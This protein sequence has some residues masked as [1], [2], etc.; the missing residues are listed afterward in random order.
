MNA[1]LIFLMNANLCEGTGININ[2]CNGGETSV[3]PRVWAG[4]SLFER[5]WA[6]T[7]KKY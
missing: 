7:K 1:N 4:P 3:F 6:E 2:F 5:K